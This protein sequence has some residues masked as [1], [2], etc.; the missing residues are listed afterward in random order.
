MDAT[1][2]RFPD[3]DA[4]PHF[5]VAGRTVLLEP[6][7]ITNVPA[8]AL[9]EVVASLAEEDGRIMNALDTLLSRAWR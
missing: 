6:L 8:R 3:S 1:R 9:G 4:A 2:F 5:Y 7:R